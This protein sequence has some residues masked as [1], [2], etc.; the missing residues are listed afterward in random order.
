M[1]ALW[2]KTRRHYWSD[3]GSGCANGLQR[4]YD[5]TGIPLETWSKI[6]R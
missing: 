5:R 4:T 1:V 6:H 2:L 3:L